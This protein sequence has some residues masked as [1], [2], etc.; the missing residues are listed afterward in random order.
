MGRKWLLSLV[1]LYLFVVWFTPLSSARF[2]LRIDDGATTISFEQL[3]PIVS[4]AVENG[5]GNTISATVRLELLTPS[6]KAV[7]TIE[8]KLTIAKGTQKLKLTLPLVSRDLL[9]KEPQ[10]LW[11]RLHYKVLPQLSDQVPP[12]EGLISISQ[13]MTDLFELRVAVSGAAREGMQYHA[14]VRAIH[15]LSQRPA[16]D[17]NVYG[18]VTLGESGS[19]LALTDSGH[20]N[21]AGYVDLEFQLPKNLDSNDFRLSIEGTR[22]LLNVKTEKEIQVITHPYVLVSTDKPLYQP[23]QTLHARATVLSTAKRAVPSKTVTV[24]ITDPEDTV[25]FQTELETSRFGIASVDWPIPDNI[26]LGDYRLHFRVNDE[27]SNSANIK[28]SRYD[29]P[30]F[31]VNVKTDRSF[32]LPGQK[33][34]VTVRG[35]YLFGEQVPRGHVRVVRDVERTWNYR[36]QTY[37]T[38]EG[39][40]YEGELRADR[41]LS[42]EFDL[43]TDFKELEEADYRRYVD[44]QYTAYLTDPSTN[45]T[46]QR[47]FNLRLTKQ[48]IHIYIVR[49]GDNYKESVHLRPT[50]YVSTF[51]A[52]GTPAEA[53]LTLKDAD[54]S[55]RGRHIIPK[56]STNE[57]GVAKISELRVSAKEP[58]EFDLTINVLAQDKA[59]RTGKHA[60]TLRFED[61]PGLRV[62][63]PKTI[64]F[65]N[66]PIPVTITSSERAATV[67]LDVV[68]DWSVIQSEL[69][70]VE[71]GR[72]SILLPYRREFKDQLVLAAYIHRGEDKNVLSTRSIIYPRPRDLRLKLQS[73]TQTY[74]PGEEARFAFQTSTAEGRAVES[75]LGIVVVDKAIEERFRTDVESEWRYATFFGDYLGVSG[76]G[77]A[78]GSVSRKVI[79]NL[80]RSKPI[81]PELDLVAEVLL[82]QYTSYFPKLFSTYEHDTNFLELFS[83]PI[84]SQFREVRSALVKTYERTRLYPTDEASLNRLLSDS[85]ITFNSLRDPWG[86]PYRP[87]FFIEGQDNLLLIK[88]AGPDKKHDTHDDFSVSQLLWPYFRSTGEAIDRAVQAFHRRTGGFIRNPNTLREELRREG[89]DLDGLRDPW[90]K[91]YLFKFEVAASHFVINVYV[92][93]KANADDPEFSVWQSKIDYFAEARPR[94]DQALSAREKTTNGFPQSAK[95]VRETLAAAGINF[96]TLRDPWGNQYYMTFSSLSFYGDQVQIEAHPVNNGPAQQRLDTKPVSSVVFSIK[97][98]SMGNDAKEGSADDFEVATFASIRSQ[99]SASDRRPQQPEVLTTFTGSTGAITGTLT[100]PN[101]AIIAGASVTA[102]RLSS[103]EQFSVRTNDEGRYLLRNL[104]AGT[105]ELQIEAQG[106]QRLMITEIFVRSSQLLQLN[107]TLQIGAV[108]E[109]VDVTAAGSSVQTT[110]ASVASTVSKEVLSIGFGDSRSKAKVLAI[111]APQQLFTPRLREFFPE[112]LLWKPELTTDKKGFARLDFKL[113]D[114][115]TTWKMSVI[116]STED[117]EIG[118]AETEIR[119]FQPFFAELDPPKVLTQGDRIS[120]PVVLRNYLNK[121]QTIELNLQPEQWFKI[122]GVDNKKTEVPGGDSI[123]ETFDLEAL[124]AVKEGKQ[125]VNA[126]GSEFSDAVQKTVLVHPDGEEKSD[127]T[128][129]LLQRSTEMVVE[130]PADTINNSSRVELKVYPNLTSH[131]WESVEGIMMRPY[132]CGEQT[133]SSTYPSLLILR[134]WKKHEPANSVL[135]EKARRYTRAG[136]QKLLGYQSPE[137]GFTYWGRGEPDLALTAYAIRFLLDAAEV[138]EVDVNVTTRA[139]Q[140]LLKKQ[141]ADGS[142]PS[143]NWDGKENSRHTALLTSFVA[144]AL[145]RMKSAKCAAG[146]TPPGSEKAP[147]DKA[148]DY[149][150]RRSEEIAEP[151]LIASYSLAAASCDPS[152]AASANRRLQKLEHVTDDGNYWALESNTPFYGWGMAGRI[153]TTALVVQ[154]LANHNSPDPVEQKKIRDSADRGLLFLLH[155]K[156]RYGVWYST[157]ATINVLDGILAMARDELSPTGSA[158]T[159]EVLLNDQRIDSLQLPPDKR[160]DGPLTTDLSAAAKIGKNRIQVRRLGNGPIASVQVVSTYWVPWSHS[161]NSI[162]RTEH[163]QTMTLETAFNKTQA[164][165]M[166]EIKCHVKAERIGFRGYGMLLAEIGLPPGADVDRSSLEKAMKDSYS[167][168]QYDI[169]PDRVVLYLWPRAGGT[170]FDFTFRPRLRMNALSSSSSVYDYYNPEA[171]AVVAPTRF[172]VK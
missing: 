5:S 57:Y 42:F 105:Y 11:Y 126:L 107:A 49:S 4:L 83:G 87:L 74:K 60:E 30:N 84:E 40:K 58:N 108:A 157:Q 112:T 139:Q 146:V 133:I 156:D 53:E 48:P 76:A 9:E 29:L 91:P 152:R 95:E 82:N 124:V 28:I 13:L 114:N 97:V 90:S 31:V 89:I 6:D 113:A 59:G 145:A 44:L 167:I 77:D 80:S 98:R 153:E 104:P 70:P 163:S 14:R 15:P 19:D 169:L 135:L 168:N 129:N 73:T 123:T 116:G 46:E 132:G 93:S 148:L 62:T 1:C 143:L 101:G 10:I 117:G 162:A 85:G 51:Y 144:R 47:R 151:Y 34:T 81:T 43:E 2:D 154:A 134:H 142:W 118:M 22:G 106:F 63:V 3:A 94:I 56:A 24:K 121:K 141:R 88:S 21:R 71:N 150:Q 65:E 99:Q 128:S 35:D 111:K 39:T 125:R 160:F 17:V 79:D 26:R 67:T 138:I 16:S 127:T 25:I 86:T 122:L 52:D 75:A 78:I 158:Q 32:Y 159:V 68:R 165:V 137:G 170:E 96:D 36:E 45:R 69:V 164:G 23:G 172:V 161:S 8:Q 102:T 72:A 41:T 50:L 149:L 130:L 171:K 37:E 38:K 12:V 147:L 110:N 92:D 20:T 33:P 155:M 120:Q 166:E 54:E 7:G 119:S 131:V 55:N 115:I 66:E 64:Y 136:Y 61:E 103:N 100:D 109:T 18:M 140:W 27:W